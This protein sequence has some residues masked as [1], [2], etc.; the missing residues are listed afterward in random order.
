[1]EDQE[2]QAAYYFY[3]LL[4][5]AKNLFL[6]YDTEPGA[7][8]GGEK[9]RFLLQ[10]ESETKYPIKR[11]QQVQTIQLQEKDEIVIPKTESIL[12]QIDQMSTGEHALSPSAL[13]VYLDCSLKY[14]Y[15]HIAKID[16]KREMTSAL[17]HV[18]FGNILHHTIEV[19][20]KKN[21]ERTQ[22]NV[23]NLD[24]FELI[25]K[26]IS[27]SIKEAFRATFKLKEHQQM[28]LTGHTLIAYN[29]VKDYV[30]RVLDADKLYAPF[31]IIHLEEKITGTIQVDGKTLNL[32][33][34]V[35]RLDMKDGIYRI[36]DY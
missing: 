18:E 36:I 10:L 21:Q 7:L 11:L 27:E 19:L 25:E 17:D 24:D 32:G 8:G 20:Y 16:E 14:Y 15:K 2:A 33:G 12:A 28:H 3:R 31:T 6:L 29:V 1:S 35:D 26:E 9:S 13:N 23:V 4:H 5:K 22:R 30:K 34:Y